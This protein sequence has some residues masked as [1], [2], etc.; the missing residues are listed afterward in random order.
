MAFKMD[1]QISPSPKTTIKSTFLDIGFTKHVLDPYKHMFTKSKDGGLF[2]FR[3]SRG[4]MRKP[5]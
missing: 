4:L 1:K 2:D 3:E 5:F